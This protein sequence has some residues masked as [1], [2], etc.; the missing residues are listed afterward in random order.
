M[1]DSAVVVE[2]DAPSQLFALLRPALLL[3]REVCRVHGLYVNFAPGKTEIVARLT[4]EDAAEQ[5]VEHVSSS[6][7]SPVLDCG[8]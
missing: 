8:E 4:G 1:D 6:E 5:W 3:I 7:G 2:A